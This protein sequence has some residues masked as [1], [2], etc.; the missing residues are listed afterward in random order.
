M[1]R[2]SKPIPQRRIEASG[3]GYKELADGLNM[4]GLEET[5]TSIT[6]KSLASWRAVHSQ[7]LFSSHV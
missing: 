5:E 1:G 3:I 4:H 2:K 6:G 7:R